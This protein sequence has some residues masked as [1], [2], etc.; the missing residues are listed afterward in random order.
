MARTEKIIAFPS[1]FFSRV[2]A[3]LYLEELDCLTPGDMI[4]LIQD[5]D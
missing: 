3:L 5:L 1:H 4:L 2:V